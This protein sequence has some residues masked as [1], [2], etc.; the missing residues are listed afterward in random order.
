MS[1]PVLKWAGGKTQLL[2]QIENFLPKAFTDKVVQRYA[3]PFVGGGA[4]FFYLQDKFKIKETYIS[5]TNKDLILLYRIVKED[6]EKLLKQLSI[7]SSNYHAMNTEEKRKEYFYKIRETYNAGISES[8]YQTLTRKSIERGSQLIFLNRTC[9]NGLYRVNSKGL[10]NVPFGKYKN[11]GIYNENNLR[12]ASNLLKNTIIECASYDGLPNKFLTN[13]L[14]YFDPPYRPLSNTSN[15][16]A[17]NKSSF[18]DKSQI[19]LANYYKKISENKNLYLILSNSDPKN[20]DKNDKFF[21][22]LYKG[23]RIN[24]VSATRIINSNSAGRGKIT[25]ILVTNMDF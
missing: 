20:S 9:F 12:A 3:E 25:E 7:I 16:T 10:F 13:S 4:L 24:R 5:D 19:D 17:Y 21:D 1:K 11:P 15:F 23:F 22:E 18:N 6:L 14:V 2:N 8:S